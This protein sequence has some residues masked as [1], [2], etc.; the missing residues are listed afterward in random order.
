MTIQPPPELKD[1]GE[2]YEVDKV[3]EKWRRHGKVQYLISWVGYPLEEK[4]WEPLS[5]LR[6]A[7]EAI[8]EFV[9]EHKPKEGICCSRV[10]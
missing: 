4:T 5:N 3:L 9:Q 2:F 6:D 8:T 7:K 10:M 1:R